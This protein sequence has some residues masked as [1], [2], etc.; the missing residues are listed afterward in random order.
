MVWQGI[1]EVSINV[2]AEILTVVIKIKG[3][4]IKMYTVQVIHTTS[5]V[6]LII[7]HVKTRIRYF[8]KSHLKE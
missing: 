6:C 2:I 4:A 1:L 5:L 8:T 7:S 3:T